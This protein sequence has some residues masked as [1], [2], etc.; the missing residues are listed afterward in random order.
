[1]KSHEIELVG[2]HPHIKVFKDKVS[3]GVMEKAITAPTSP[4]LSLGIIA[5]NEADSIGASLESVFRQSLFC[6]LHERKLTCEIL[7]MANGCTDDTAEIARKCFESRVKTHPFRDS[8]TCR[9][10]DLVERGKLNAWNVFV[11]QL[12]ETEA[13]WLFLM[14]GDIIIHQRD[15]LWNML[16]ILLD[17]T[18]AVMA[19]DRPLKN[20]SLKAR[21]SVLE[22]ISL[23]TSAMTQANSAQVTGQLYCIRA[24]AARNIYLPRDL[25]ACEDGFI[26]TVIA[27]DFLTRP[28]SSERIMVADEAS[29]V[30]EAYLSGSDILKNQKRQMMGHT[31][32][33]VLVDKLLKGIDINQRKHLGQFL[34]DLERTDPTWLKR[35]INEHIRTTN[36]CWQLFPGLLLSRFRG[37]THVQGIRRWVYFPVALIGFFVTLISSWQAFRALKRGCTNYWPDT[38]SLHLAQ[39]MSSAEPPQTAFHT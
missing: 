38:K 26:K 21:P 34:C 5:C 25:V 11:H 14:D 23:A 22:R 10:V 37:L 16:A 4:D 9:V 31:M 32:V 1:L 33:H 30:F 18:E 3:K 17:H 24:A 19:V 8:F 7:C 29:H 15:T 13:Q 36:H 35:L 27:T 39:Q 20:I 2:D 12:S 28:A 6:K